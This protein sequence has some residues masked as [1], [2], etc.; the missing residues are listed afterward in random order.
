VAEYVE[1]LDG[2]DEYTA[3]ADCLWGPL[4]A[5]IPQPEVGPIVLFD[6]Q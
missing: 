6:P 3:V 4:V 5:L 1:E 2:I